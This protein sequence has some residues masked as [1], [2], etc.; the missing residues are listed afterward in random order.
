MKA[1]S[2]SGKSIQEIRNQ[3]ENYLKDDFKPT[4]A[5]VFVTLNMEWQKV[6]D[7]LI[8]KDIAIFGAKAAIPF[9]DKSLVNEGIVVMLLEINPKS[10]KITLS[11]IAQ[12]SL[13]ESVSQICNIGKNSFSRP[14]FLI[15]V[16]DVSN[17]GE[18][19]MKNFIQKIGNRITITDISN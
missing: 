10:F 19:I 4:L 12:N 11:D 16:A 9:D 3:L 18:E 17:S 14:A 7:L 15:S 5:F 8:E 13:S 6:R 1:K 2:I